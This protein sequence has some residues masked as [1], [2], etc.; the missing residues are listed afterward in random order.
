MVVY[1]EH[2]V[3]ISSGQAKKLYKARKN[4]I[5]VT[6][7]LSKSNKN[8]TFKLPLTQTQINMIK[9]SKDGIELKLSATQLKHMEKTGGFLPLLAMIPTIAAVL[10]GVGAVANTIT[11]A[12]SA[13]KTNAEQA[14]HNR[15]IEEQQGKSGS[16]MLSNI[17]EKIGLG[18]KEINKINDGGCVS[19]NGYTIGSGLWL[20]PDGNYEGSGL[21]ISPS[22]FLE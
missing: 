12:V 11:N 15:A 5:G 2:G 4:N 9:S 20:S 19:C 14:R 7:K 1:Y 18:H 3:N 21:F 8:G 17:L 22:P 16:G 13:A 6:I 10:G